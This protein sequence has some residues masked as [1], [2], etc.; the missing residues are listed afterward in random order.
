MSGEDLY[1]Q[2][3]IEAQREADRAERWKKWYEKQAGE[4]AD[5]RW[6]GFYQELAE[7]CQ[8]EGNAWI[9]REENLRKALGFSKKSKK[10]KEQEALERADADRGGSSR[11]KSEGRRIISG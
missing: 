11:L 4:V 3:I 10:D 9:S 7:D 1:D 8:Q 5:R 6:K 2:Q